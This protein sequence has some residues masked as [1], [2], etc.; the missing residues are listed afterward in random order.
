MRTAFFAAVAATLT[1]GLAAATPALASVDLAAGEANCDLY[2]TGCLFDATPPD[3][4]DADLILAAYNAGHAPP[5]LTSLTLLGKSDD[6]DGGGDPL[7]D[8]DLSADGFSFTVSNLPFDVAFFTIKA[9]NQQILLF[10][11]DPATNTFSG[12][13][14]RI[15]KNG[16]LAGISHV[17]FYGGECVGR[18]CGGGGNEIPEPSTWALMILGFGSAGAMLRRRRTLVA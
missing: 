16:N 18:D 6:E 17:S 1:L 2:T 3:F 11:L 15:F 9:A 12:A 8:F 10:G 7:Y 4:D 13:N 5:P 14:S